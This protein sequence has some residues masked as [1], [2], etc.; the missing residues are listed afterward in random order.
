MEKLF[1]Q[2]Q[3]LKTFTAEIE[4]IEELHGKFHVVLDKTAFFPGGGGQYC[5]LGK[6][7][8]IEVLDVYEKDKLIYHVLEKK[9]IKIHKV[10]CSLDWKR[11]SNGMNQHLAQH[12]LSACIFKLFNINTIA[13]HHGSEIS[14]ID[15]NARLTEEQIKECEEFANNVISEALKVEFLTPTKRELKNINLRRKLPNTNE[16]IRVVKIGDLDMVACC[17][18][19]PSSTLDLRLIKIKKYEKHKQGTRI[20]FLAGEKAVQDSFLKDEFTSSICKYLNC[21]EYEAINGIKNLSNN[22]K[23]TNEENKKLRIELSRYEIK[24]MIE[25]AYKIGDIKIIK[26]IY[27]NQNIKYVNNLVSKLTEFENIIT[28]IAIHSNEKANLIFSCSKNLNTLNMGEILKDAISLIDGK[29]GGSQT[30]AQGA[31]KNNSNLDGTLDYAF[32]KV[33]NN[34]L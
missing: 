10:K 13:V 18:V 16:E 17:G 32:N 29:G 14:T 11:R 19:H 26:S 24:D 12:V 28:L 20:E 4:K 33:K 3:Y 6:I 31:G 8:E 21:N 25:N 22:L 23:E 7:E 2:N 9:P 34:F 15:F 5:D 30:L 1:Y 27:T